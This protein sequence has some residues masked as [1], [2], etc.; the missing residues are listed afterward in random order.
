[1][2]LLA[3][4]NP[5]AFAQAGGYLGIAAA[6][7]AE[8]G[9]LVGIF[10]PGGDSTLF[11]AGLLAA[12]GYLDP[13]VLYPLVFFAAL[14]GDS[15]GYWIGRR[16]GR[17]LFDR[18]DSRW[19]KHEYIE[20]T[21]RFYQRF[22]ALTI[23]FA[24]FVPIVRTIAPTMAGVGVMR[25][26]KFAAFNAIGAFFWSVLM[27]SLG[28]FLG[29]AFPGVEHYILPAALGIIVLSLVPLI[30]AFLQRKLRRNRR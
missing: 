10:I 14:L 11:A 2:H 29:Q 24:R 25:Y 8:S 5:S 3:V 20:R 6:V 27:L 17:K 1:M 26:P 9:I 18:P 12:G 21:E 23:V 30:V 4:L 7:Y 15:T 19:F 13:M 16:F 22:G 28:Y